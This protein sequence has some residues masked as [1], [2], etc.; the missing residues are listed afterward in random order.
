MANTVAKPKKIA[1]KENEVNEIC[2]G[3]HPCVDLATAN[4]HFRQ[5]CTQISLSIT[6]LP[7]CRYNVTQS[8]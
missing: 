2:D 4:Q 5:C 8:E 3:I 6:C 1:N 7:Y